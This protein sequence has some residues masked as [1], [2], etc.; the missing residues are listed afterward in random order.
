MP[1]LPDLTQVEKDKLKID[2]DFDFRDIAR[3]PFSDI[4]TNE[5]GMFKWSGVY[6]QLQKGF[7]M[8]RLRM[9][10][11]LLTSE[12][13]ERAADLA[14]TYGQSDLCITTRQCLQFHWIRKEDIHK[15]IEG[16]E[17]VGVLSRNA[18]GDVSRNVV[19]CS[20]QGVCPHEIGDTRVMLDAIAEDDDILNHQRNFP[21][22]HKIS[23]SGCGRACG[24]TLMNCQSW[25][26]VTRLDDAGGELVGWRYYAGGGLGA[27]PYM[28]KR[29]FDWVPAELVVAVTSA[30]SEVYRREGNRRKRGYARLK[31]VV[32]QLGG[33][34]FADAV[35]E[36]LEER[37]VEGRVQIEY[38]TS[39]EP[40]I[41]DMFLDGQ[42]VVPQRQEG[43]NTVRVMILRSELFSADA[44]RVAGWA[45][46]YGNGEVMFT[47]RQ[48]LELRFVP[49]EKLDALNREIE[50][51]GYRVDG[52][53][54]LPDMVACVGTTQCNLAVSDT[55]NTYRKLYNEFSADRSLWDKVGHL[56]IHMN[57]C[58]NSC[59]QHWIGDI[60]LRG[61]RERNGEGSDEGFGIF[62]GGSLA[63]KGHIAEFVRDVTSGQLTETVRTM[64]QVYL[65]RREDEEETFGAFSRRVG[66][67]G[68]D[69]LLGETP[70][71][72]HEPVNVR[73]L[74][75]QPLFRQVMSEVTNHDQ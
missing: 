54:R 67:A 6:H 46:T 75:L 63:G 2:P 30:A 37:R 44:R 62:V 33:K 22:K 51:A 4:S 58:P 3:R 26:P 18:C 68:F 70:T 23:L 50:E 41:G 73:N 59:A 7:F 13:V 39:A 14:E 25:H 57:G 55:P 10:G 34:G 12:Q 69:T 11:G 31:V 29:I 9:P 15:V 36:V 8:I 64:L 32:D 27:R 40:E 20:L 72:S 61:T 21:R 1:E 45:R 53:E 66:G 60:G 47:N 49:D 19:S 43:F 16:M 48:N 52:H 17:E 5:I 24:Q 74:N 56:R 38:A 71:A 65:D 28:A 35:M 42:S